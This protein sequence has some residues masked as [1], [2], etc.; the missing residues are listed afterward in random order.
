MSSEQKLELLVKLINLVIVPMVG[1]VLAII[2]SYFRNRKKGEKWVLENAKLD[3]A[4][5]TISNSVYNAVR[6]V[7]DTFANE[8][9]DKD[10]KLSKENQAKA[11]NKAYSIAMAT[12]NKEAYQ[13]VSNSIED[14]N[15]LI[16]TYIEN[17]VSDLKEVEE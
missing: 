13:F 10:G 14:V 3:K 17:S 6:V 16:K 8:L 4:F 5:N 11:F 15:E 12:M 7:A 2:G 9:R 1:A